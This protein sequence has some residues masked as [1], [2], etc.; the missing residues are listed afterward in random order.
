[1]TEK[2]RRNNK[3]IEEALNERLQLVADILKMPLSNSTNTSESSDGADN[4][5]N[6]ILLSAVS[7]GIVKLL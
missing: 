6:K 5:P 1:M 4:D 3:I 2:L 7:Q